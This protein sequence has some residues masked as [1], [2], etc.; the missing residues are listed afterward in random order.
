M[1]TSL[2]VLQQ[3]LTMGIY[4]LLGFLLFRTGRISKEGSR[5][6]AAILINLVIPAMTI[7]GFLREFSRERLVLL[8]WSFLLSAVALLFSIAV[9]HLLYRKN[10]INLFA[11]AYSNAGFI[12]IP[13]VR[14]ALGE[15]AVFLVISY[16]ALLNVFQVAHGLPVLKRERVRFQ[17][18]EYLKSPIILSAV[19]G[20]LVF[21][22]GLGN[23]L[24]PLLTGAVSGLSSTNAPLAML[25][26]GVYLAESNL[27]EMLTN[28]RILLVSGVRLLLI[29]GL[30]LLL[31]VLFPVDPQLKMV[32]LLAA[33]APVGANVA[34]YSQL[35]GS[36]SSYAGELVAQSTVLSILSLPVMVWL[37]GFL[38][39]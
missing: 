28:G 6:I 8:G 35:A 2:I 12:G 26:L 18:R 13:L 27:K 25:L 9:A 19:I 24:P 16:V 32:V 31:L 17:L 7:N 4:M 10:P 11:A 39:K 21:V 5:S 14:A 30:T 22:T 1:N 23:R 36:D 33:A 15:E 29:P 20:L 34:V 3:T 37:A 38:L